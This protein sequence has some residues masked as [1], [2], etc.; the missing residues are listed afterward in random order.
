MPVCDLPLYT[1]S[2]GGKLI[3]VND[4]ATDIDERAEVVIHEKTGFILPLIVEEIKK[5]R[6]ENKDLV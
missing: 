1:L 2:E 6:E 5:L 3:I 4:E